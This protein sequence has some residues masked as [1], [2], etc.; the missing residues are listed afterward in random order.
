V[1]ESFVQVDPPYR[2]GDVLFF[3]DTEH[4]DAFHSCIYIADDIVYSKN[5]RNLLSPW[6]LT[7]L[8]DIK[9]VYLFD[10]NGRVQGFRHKKST[11]APAGE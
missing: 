7:K 4:G 2:F 5:G 9:H 6:I 11:S 3:L 1:L 10:G 8:D